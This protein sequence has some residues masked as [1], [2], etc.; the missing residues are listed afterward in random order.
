MS[1]RDRRLAASMTVEASIALPLFIF[2]FVNI[3]TVFNIVRAQSD[4]GAAL[5]QTGNEMA[6]MAFDMRFAQNSEDGAVTGADAIAGAAGVFYARGR[7][8]EY[9]E[10]S[11]DKSCVS[12]GAEG[13]SFMWSRI[14]LGNDIIDLVADYKV[15]PLI[16]LIG[17]KE[18]KVRSR[19][20]GH[21]FTGYDISM[22]LGADE[23]EEEVVFVTEHGEVYHRS[24]GCSHLR[25]SARSVSFDSVSR[26]RNNY[27]GKYYP[28]EYCGGSIGG[29]NV[30]VTDYG[31]KYHGSM[32][33]PGLR[34]KVYTIK[35]SEVGGRP[36]CSLCGY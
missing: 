31:D 17:F 26:E 6:L 16:P 4:I 11:L 33:C 30:F 13:L 19:F 12:G 7:V 34:R 3:M 8:R 23:G 29:G 9:L 24:T 36:P 5:H 28:C 15:H 10:G 1:C 20:Y 35:L 22:G 27:G 14:L 18:F 21:A 2:F 32:G 25:I